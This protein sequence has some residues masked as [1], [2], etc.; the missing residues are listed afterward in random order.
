M[1]WK[2]VQAGTSFTFPPDALQIGHEG[3]NGQP[4]FSARAWH[5]GGLHLGKA[6]QHLNR[7]CTISYGGGEVTL[8]TF[9]VLCGKPE[10]TLLKWICFGHGEKVRVEGWQPVEGGREKDGQS[11]FIAK[12]EWEG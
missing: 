6:G 1:T 11:L 2:L 9:E 3:H 8:D 7:G 4:L 12:G 5:Q 10:P